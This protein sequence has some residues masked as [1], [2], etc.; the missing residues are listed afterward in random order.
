MK[1]TRKDNM[2][3]MRI[4]CFTHET[5]WVNVKHGN[6]SWFQRCK[7]TLPE[8]VGPKSSANKSEQSCGLG[9]DRELKRVLDK[10]QKIIERGLV[11]ECH[12]DDYR[13]MSI[14]KSRS[15]REQ[16]ST[17]QV[18]AT[19]A[20]CNYY[21]TQAMKYHA[22]AVQATIALNQTFEQISPDQHIPINPRVKVAAG[23]QNHISTP[24]RASPNGTNS[25]ILTEQSTTEMEKNMNAKHCLL[26][27]SPSP[28]DGL[29][30]RMPSSA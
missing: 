28:R 9:S 19:E 6:K 24:T 23:L 25:F 21:K 13:T 29:L 17:A 26:Y 30:S 10:S 8:N 16:S 2:S 5:H 7:L 4:T 15:S 14:K 27:T 11:S 18:G 12:E 22:D 1:M 3:S 20:E